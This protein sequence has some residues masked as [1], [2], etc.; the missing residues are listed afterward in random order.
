MK[1]LVWTGPNEMKLKTASYPVPKEDEVLIKVDVVGICGSEIE[2]FLGHNSLRVPPL[3]MGHEFCGYIEQLGSN[4]TNFKVGQKAIINPLISCGICDRCRKGTENLCDNREILGIHRP[5]SFSQYVVVPK[6]SVYI[7]EET[8][9]SYSASLAEPLACCVRA[10]RRA[11]AHHPFSNVL[12]YGAGAIG[13]LSGYVAQILGANKVII[14]DINKERL[15]T[16]EQAGIEYVIH[17]T[18]ENVE[19]K[20]ATI[21]GEKGVDVII[22]AAGFLPTRKEAMHIINAGGVIMNIGLGINETPLPLNDQIRSEITILGSFS[23]TKQ[24]FD[25]AIQLLVEGK[26]THEGWSEVRPLEEGQQAF[27]DLVN[28]KV[29]NSKIFLH[30]T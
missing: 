6:E 3:V 5:G 12:I 11:L 15:Q 21:T 16:I 18:T 13:L 27:T 1:T 29:S 22:D 17:S 24:D 8:L 9:N 10:V 14:A 2:G 19:E 28:G 25:D 26:V 7:V 30:V 23:Y 20:L 4:V